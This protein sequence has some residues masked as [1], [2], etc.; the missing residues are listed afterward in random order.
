MRIALYIERDLRLKDEATR[1]R[2]NEYLPEV[3]SAVRCAVV[4]PPECR[5]AQQK[6]ANKTDCRH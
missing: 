4:F 3:R 2:L 1:A 5:R 6:L